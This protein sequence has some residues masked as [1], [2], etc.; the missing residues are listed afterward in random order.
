MVLCSSA[1]YAARDV[2]FNLS[3]R[4]LATFLNAMTAAD[5]TIYPFSTVHAQDFAN[6]LDVYCDAVFFPN[7]T[8]H[9][10][11]RE[12]WRL[13]LDEASPGGVRYHG[14][15]FNEMKGVVTDP[16][17]WFYYQLKALRAGAPLDRA[18]LTVP[19][20]GAASPYA[21]NS[22]GD[23]LAIPSLTHDELR[24][25]HA[26]Y[27][28]PANA[29]FFSYGDLPLAHHIEYLEDNVLS[30]VPPSPAGSIVLPPLPRTPAA[31]RA[32]I[33]GPFDSLSA[34]DAQVYHGSEWLAHDLGSASPAANLNLQL[35]SSLLLNG[36]ASPVYKAVI[37]TGLAAD[38]SQR[39][40]Q[41]TEMATASLGITFQGISSKA[42]ATDR[43]DD[44]VAA[45]LD[46][47][48]ADGFD[49]ARIDALLH[50]I[51]ISLKARPDNY[52]LALS[53]SLL[54]STSL[55]ASL[56]DLVRIEETLDEF[57]ADP[58]GALA[59]TLDAL[60]ASP[61]VTLTM[62]P[63][64][65]FLASRDAAEAAALE[66]AGAELSA[67]AKAELEAVTKTF[68]ARESE[69][70]S[71]LADTLPAISIDECSEE[72]TR[73]NETVIA[74]PSGIY[75]HDAP[76]NG[77]VY[78]R[79]LTRVPDEL[80]PES[81]A[82]LPLYASLLPSLGTDGGRGK[83]PYATIDQELQ[84]KAGSLSAGI[85]L[86]DALDSS[87]HF[88]E[89]VSVSG[90]FL[91]AKSADA[92]NLFAE[93]L[94]AP[95]WTDTERIGTLVASIAGELSSSIQF[96]GHSFAALNARSRL[97]RVNARSE[98]FDGLSQ[99]NVLV[100]L[101]NELAAVD[102]PAESPLLASVMDA[103]GGLH[104]RM[105]AGAWGQGSAFSV[106]APTAADYVA[107]VEDFAGALG[108]PI[109]SSPL[110]A[111]APSHP[112]GLPSPDAFAPAL[113]S[114]YVVL[115][116][117]VH[118]VASAI[119]TVPALHPDATPL[120]LLG[121]ILSSEY[122]L[123][124]V[125]QKGGAYGAG[126]SQSSGAFTFF[127]YRDPQSTATLDAF[128]GSEAFCNSLSDAELGAMLARAKL[129][130]VARL[131][132]PLAPSQF[133]AAYFNAGVEDDVRQQ[134]R[135]ALFA[136]SVDDLRR[137][138]AEHLSASAPRSSTI[139]GP[140]GASVPAGDDWVVVDPAAN[141]RG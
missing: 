85:S 38:Y 81:A 138:A 16:A 46:S 55:G 70:V 8:K 1:K 61:P 53:S 21:Y 125:R 50:Q 110:P 120:S 123:P 12:G 2:F 45:A 15:V 72:L 14:I 119:P 86:A 56:P 107:P 95:D 51:E 105:I 39:T 116:Y 11:D 40:G 41:N 58:Q 6:I 67:G 42:G 19:R 66:V 91:E 18:S 93:I 78:V 80:A 43:I 33:A 62:E 79:A 83:V 109:T 75:T 7:L 131:D 94:T 68:Y 57:K 136:A 103:L 73:R 9:D 101:A 134:L 35:L 24:A 111:S 36:A 127:S 4:T 92:L 118:Y 130:G 108:A 74:A 82:L 65:E 64:P 124:V 34:P 98:L 97:N 63:E 89:R 37:E 30:R 104:A 117:Q 27:Y 112:A 87:A 100:P 28:S 84:M 60:L 96:S 126:A 115:P 128:A 102:S 54:H 137:V 132:A 25:A 5:S 20:G 3:Q 77:L 52:G 139:I 114:E 129:R 135:S 113:R 88:T 99:L 90:S 69:D 13:E 31:E 32:V 26:K 121:S 44:A 59:A 76:T 49:P 122:L 17:A 140:G 48:R 10:F 47:V 22:G 141:A 71:A 23:P 133:G 106:V 29:L